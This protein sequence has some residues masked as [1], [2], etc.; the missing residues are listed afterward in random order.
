MDMFLA[1]QGDWA[2]LGSSEETVQQVRL[3]ALPDLEKFVADPSNEFKIGIHKESVDEVR[4][5]Q[6]GFSRVLVASSREMDV[7][8]ER[9][10]LWKR[11]HWLVKRALGW[12]GIDNGRGR[13][14]LMLVDPGTNTLIVNYA[15]L[16]DFGNPYENKQRLNLLKHVLNRERVLA[17]L[18]WLLLHQLDPCLISIF[19]I[20][21]PVIRMVQV[22]IIAT[23]FDLNILCD[24]FLRPVKIGLTHDA[25]TMS[26]SPRQ[27][28]TTIG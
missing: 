15:W 26:L 2:L 24:H 19:G 20:E 1:E 8:A 7:L 27:A 5:V 13:G 18:L 23:Y 21:R 6:D 16:K 22:H 4:K 14:T 25:S 10:R 17:H 9:A 12:F 28:Q 11:D 3:D